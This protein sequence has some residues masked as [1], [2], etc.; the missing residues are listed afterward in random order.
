MAVHHEE[1]LVD[2]VQFCDQLR[3]LERCQRFTGACGVP[4]VA[5]LIRVLDAVQDFLH[6]VILVRA[7][8]HQAFISIVQDDV[9]G[10]HLAHGAFVK[11][12]GRKL[13]EIVHRLIVGQCPVEGKLIAT[14]GIIGEIA[15]VDTVGDDKKL[16]VVEKAAEGS[17][18]VAL[19]LVVGLLQLYAAFLKLNL[20]ERKAVD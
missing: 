6:S 16:D 9:F 10:N 14:V 17:F 18:L 4:D 7:E 2:A 20:Y 19:H 5:V 13:A 15:R 8:D 12:V 3:R 11:E 1:H